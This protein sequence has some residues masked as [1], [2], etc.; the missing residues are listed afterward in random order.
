MTKSS[1]KTKFF[2]MSMKKSEPDELTHH[3]WQLG[4]LT[5]GDPWLSVPRYLEGW[6]FQVVLM[7]DKDKRL[8]SFFNEH[9]KI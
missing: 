1:N 3:T 2:K 8:S 9:E 6:L 5:I 7:Y 4:C